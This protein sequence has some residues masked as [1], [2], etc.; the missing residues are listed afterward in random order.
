[1]GDNKAR[2]WRYHHE[3]GITMHFILNYNLFIFS[4]NNFICN[5]N[6]SIF[7]TNSSSEILW[8]D[9]VKQ[10]LIYIWQKGPDSTQ[11]SRSTIFGWTTP[12]A[13]T[14][15]QQAK[16]T[17]HAQDLTSYGAVSI[18]LGS[19]LFFAIAYLFTCVN[20]MNGPFFIII[21]GYISNINIVIWTQTLHSCYFDN[22]PLVDFT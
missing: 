3:L 13:H 18:C 11:V 15:S 6:N 12:R 19:T 5:H 22:F 14:A 1:M 4:H 9:D 21:Q 10:K 2:V 20:F 16:W 8:L 7:K 17:S